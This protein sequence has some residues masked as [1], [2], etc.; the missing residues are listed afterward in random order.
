MIRRILVPL[1]GTTF[2][3]LALPA[4]TTLA[5]TTGAAIDLVHVHAPGPLESV[6]DCDLHAVPGRGAARGCREQ[7]YHWLER[8]AS[9]LRMESCVSVYTHAVCGNVSE[10]LCEEIAGLS[11]DLVVM[12]THARRGVARVRFGSVA[13]S[14]VRDAAAPV[15][16]V[17]AGPEQYSSR[18]RIRHIL[19]V[20]D[21]SD[22]GRQIVPHA[23]TL[24]SSTGARLSMLRWTNSAQI[25][26][27]ADRQ[28]VDVIALATHGRGGLTRLL[29]GSTAD[30]ILRD[31]RRPVLLIR[32]RAG[33]TQLPSPAPLDMGGFSVGGGG[34]SVRDRHSRS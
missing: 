7:A 4:A 15:L 13:E 31:T 16:L 1:D 22:F 23:R 8:T 17:Q 21:D 12:T 10:L 28:D 20:Y 33:S 29:L 3:E 2:S 32:P 24:A 6:I 34:V 30:E 26:A 27:Y 11:A 14:L 19:A 18:V 5:R 9:A 25:R